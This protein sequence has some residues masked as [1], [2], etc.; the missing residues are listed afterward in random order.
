MIAGTIALGGAAGPHC[1]YGMRRGTIVLA[2]ARPSLPA[3]FLAP[4]LEAPAWAR[5][6]ADDLA[7]DLAGDDLTG[8]EWLRRGPLQRAL[9]DR[10]VAGT[11][12]VLSPPP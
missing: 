8:T 11:G 4:R 9:G 6:L 5:L 1:G 12:E 2:T 10:S 3:T 7:D